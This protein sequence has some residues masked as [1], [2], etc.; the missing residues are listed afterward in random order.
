MKYVLSWH[1]FARC[2][3]GWILQ[4]VK[5]VLG[6]CEHF[7]PEPRILTRMDG[8]WFFPRCGIVDTVIIHWGRQLATAANSQ[9]GGRRSRYKIVFAFHAVINYPFL[10][11]W[12]CIHR[13]SMYAFIE[14][15]EL[16]VA[17]FAARRWKRKRRAD[18]NLQFSKTQNDCNC[19][20]G[21]INDKLSSWEITSTKAT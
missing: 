9:Y 14:H 12:V 1:F 8:N 7:R 13:N 19:T 3:V 5:S 18:G 11:L 4:V 2:F 10:V 15:I 6:A 16:H 21:M 20:W 17:T